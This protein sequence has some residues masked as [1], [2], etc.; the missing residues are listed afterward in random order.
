VFDNIQKAFSF[1]FAV[2]VPIAGLSLLPVFFSGWPLLLLPVH[3]VFLEL[4]I[5]P[6]CSLV[7][8]AEPGEPDLMSRPPRDPRARMITWS[9]LAP[10]LLQGASVLAV[11]VGVF[12]LTRGDHGTDAARALTFAALVTSFVAIIITNRSWSASLLRILRTPNAAQWWVVLGATGFLALV[13][14]WPPARRLFSFGPLPLGDLALSLAA[15]LLCVGWFEVLKAVR[16]RRAR[17]A[18]EPAR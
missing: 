9:A 10:S 14:S 8:E 5:D 7:F 6:A 18:S 11:C 16:R 4:V 12:L 13:L 17:P 15:G 2:H 3:I 1:T